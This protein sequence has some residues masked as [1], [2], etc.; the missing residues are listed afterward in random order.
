MNVAKAIRECNFDELY[1]RLNAYAYKKLKTINIKNFDGIEPQDFVANVIEK[2][3]NGIRNWDSEKY[4]IEEFFFGCLKSE[5][6]AFF[7][8]KKRID[9]K[10]DFDFFSETDSASIDDLN[11]QI[12]ECFNKMS[13]SQEEIHLFNLWTEGI[14]KRKEIAKELSITEKE[15]DNIRKRLL[16]KLPKIRETVNI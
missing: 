16:R 13:T 12:L 1:D 11:G 10:E 15:V 5:I 4:N 9:D 2:S 14:T 3:L 8:K 7:K 6:D